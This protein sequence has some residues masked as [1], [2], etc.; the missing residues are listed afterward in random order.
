MKWLRF[1]AE[2]RNALKEAGTFRPDVILIDLFLK[3]GERSAVDG[4]DIARK[5]VAERSWE[6]VVITH[7]TQEEDPKVS[8]C[9]GPIQKSSDMR[10]LA[11]ALEQIKTG[12]DAPLPMEYT[13][14]KRGFRR[15][16]WDR[17]GR[18]INSILRSYRQLMKAEAVAV[19]AYNV[20]KDRAILKYRDP[21]ELSVAFDRV[22]DHIHKSPIRDL[23]YADE[24]HKRVVYPGLRTNLWHWMRKLLSFQG[25][26]G[27]RLN[28]PDR[29]EVWS[30]FAF[31]DESVD[32]EEK[33]QR[34][35]LR[36]AATS[37]EDACWHEYLESASDENRAL[38]EKG[39]KVR[40]LAH[41][42]MHEADAIRFVLNDIAGSIGKSSSKSP[43][44]SLRYPIDRCLDMHLLTKKMLGTWEPKLEPI[45]VAKVLGDCTYLYRLEGDDT[46][47][48]AWVDVT[49]PAVHPGDLT[50]L[51]DEVLLRDVINN[52]LLNAVTAV[53]MTKDWRKE[54]PGSW[55]QV[56]VEAF[57]DEEDSDWV[58]I[59][60]HDTGCGI[61][62][63]VQTRM[64]DRDYSTTG[65]TGLGMSICRQIVEHLE[66]SLEVAR[67]SM[68]VGTTFELRLRAGHK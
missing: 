11:E 21:K 60:V 32:P 34:D 56:C 10:D 33:E 8:G 44:P 20:P 64:W 36:D 25:A 28:T 27:I 53:R 5:L 29:D 26:Q 65:G 38:L 31:Y 4:W 18:Q 41:D 30:L 66:G 13:Q 9:W 24:H 7:L 6:I 1:E 59:R 45:N 57:A 23:A 46:S 12:Q 2:W 49:E 47:Y 17:T 48:A 43:G 37:I 22:R 54:K 15:R 39:Q 35:L 42:V 63:Y 58:K 55:G 3:Q 67:T 68:Y 16:H 51:G 62:H 40:E 61:P 50:V 52:L 14:P 19:F